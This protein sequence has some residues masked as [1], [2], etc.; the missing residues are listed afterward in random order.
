MTR[1]L[2]PKKASGYLQKA[3]NSLL[4]ARIG[5][6]KGAYDNAVMSSVHSAINALDGLITAYVGKRSSGEHRDVLSLLK[7]ILTQ[8][9]HEIVGKQ[10]STLLGMKNESEYQPTLMSQKDA[11]NAI[12]WAERILNAVKSK[13]KPD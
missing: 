13:L 8:N 2:D 6:E 7:G 5:L 9:E 4:M 3:A 11:E 1:T 10:F 12:K